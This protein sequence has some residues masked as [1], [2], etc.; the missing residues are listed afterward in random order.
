MLIL[1][2]YQYSPQILDWNI[3]FLKLEKWETQ[4]QKNSTNGVLPKN[5]MKT[6]LEI[7]IL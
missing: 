2:I 7:N 5:R 6:F 3:L 4:N 1:Q